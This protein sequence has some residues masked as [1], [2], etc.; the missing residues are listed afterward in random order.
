MR[1]GLVSETTIEDSRQ[2]R[3]GK[4]RGWFS[5]KMLIIGVERVYHVMT[6][7]AKTVIAR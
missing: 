6:L 4:S 7:L 2:G 1:W 3:W 5:G